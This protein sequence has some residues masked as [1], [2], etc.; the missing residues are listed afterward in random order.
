MK[1]KGLAVRRLHD[2]GRFQV[3]DLAPGLNLLVGPNGSGK[4]SVMNA[5]RAV[6]WGTP[7]L[8]HADLVTVWDDGRDTWRAAL[9]GGAAGWQRGGVDVPPPEV[10][11]AALAA[12]WVVGLRELLT[13]GDTEQTLLDRVRRQMAGG[14]DLTGLLEGYAGKRWPGRAEQKALREQ[15]D[16]LRAIEGRRA[17]LARRE[18]GL[19]ALRQQRLGALAARDEAERLGQALERERVGAERAAAEER[20]AGFPDGVTVTTADA[21][22][23]LR[24]WDEGLAE[25]RRAADA[26]RHDLDRAAEAAR[27]AGID[28]PLE[29]GDLAAAREHARQVRER[30]RDAAE[31]R[32]AAEAARAE[33]AR[34]RQ[35]LAPDL[36][37]EADG[38][39]PDLDAVQA[40]AEDVLRAR[41]AVD[42]VEARLAVVASELEGLGPVP[43][44]VE[45][46]ALGRAAALLEG[47]AVAGAG[48]RWPAWRLGLGGLLMVAGGARGAGEPL[49]HRPPRLGG[50]AAPGAP[51]RAPVRGR[52]RGGEGAVAR[53]RRRPGELGHR[54]RGRDP[55]AGTG[56]PGRRRPGAD[57]RGRPPAPQAGAQ[58]APGRARRPRRPAGRSPRGRHR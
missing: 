19:A 42:E 30:A 37:P 7:R 32:R 11:D 36:D 8:P 50:R 47:A 56:A 41:A 38:P 48:A 33:V 16:A 3:D 15:R 55:E 10:P 21:R 23:H 39:A 35:A 9:V 22:D 27:A 17:E 24:E 26:A 31:A 29:G 14:Y 49:V 20:V 43:D 46:E 18:D 34:A 13:G 58:P 28:A 1:L 25:A 53:R 44:A 52:R 57:P 40:W 45:A 5:A 54:G 4:T 2:L 12:N 51:G 6:L